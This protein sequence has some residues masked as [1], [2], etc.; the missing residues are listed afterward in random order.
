M[1]NMSMGEQD[2]FYFLKIL[3]G[4]PIEKALTFV[5]LKETTIDEPTITIMLKQGLASRDGLCSSAKSYFH[6][7]QP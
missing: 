1:I 5:T 2:T 3:C 7:R 6:G 4:S